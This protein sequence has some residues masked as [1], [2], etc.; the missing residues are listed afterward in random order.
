MSDLEKLPSFRFARALL[1]GLPIWAEDVPFNDIMSRVEYSLAPWPRFYLLYKLAI[2]ARNI[3]GDI[4]E[5]GVYKG[6][7]AGY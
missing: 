4:A 5:I 3:D 1:S 2:N 6:G 7:T